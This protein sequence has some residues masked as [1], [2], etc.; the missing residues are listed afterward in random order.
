MSHWVC[1]SLCQSQ[2]KAGGGLAANADHRA[3]PTIG[4]PMDGDIENGTDN[5]VVVS[6]SEWGEG[7]WAA[8]RAAPA[9]SL[10]VCREGR[11][12]LGARMSRCLPPSGEPWTPACSHFIPSKPT[13]T[14][15]S[16]NLPRSPGRAAA[17]CQGQGQAQSCTDGGPS[18]PLCAKDSPWLAKHL[19]PLPHS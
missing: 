4:R 6:G 15:A 3:E 18:H 5:R 14:L 17:D 13:C 16:Q 10:A 2:E 12:D 19:S 7:S 9:L 1:R 11:I 8:P